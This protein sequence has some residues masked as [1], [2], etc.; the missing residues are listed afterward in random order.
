LHHTN[1]DTESAP[2]RRHWL[3]RLTTGVALAGVAGAL[4]TAVASPASAAA[5]SLGPGQR[6][7]GGGEIA[8]GGYVLIMQTDGN[9]VEYDSASHA[10]W[11]SN[12]AGQPG[13]FVVMQTDGN[14]VVY[15]SGGSWRWQSGTNGYGNASLA[16]Q[17]DGN[18]VVYSSGGSPLWAKSWTQSPSGAQAYAQVYFS[19]FGWSTASQYSPL[20]SLWNR[21]SNWRW[22]ATNPSS[23]AYGIPQSLPA[24]KMAANGPDWQTDDLTQVAW[25]LSY[26]S[27]RYGTPQGAWNH[28]VSYGWY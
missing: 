3:R 15:S 6:L 25:G 23:G 7:N 20:V 17:T 22:N 21:E 19:H 10:L 4:L 2:R 13:N 1:E 8:A 28:E 11:N 12:T 24:S 9:L 16:I 27:G 26:I 14:L 5:S 18:V